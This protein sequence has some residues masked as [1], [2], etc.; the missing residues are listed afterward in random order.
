MISS[1]H[2]Q[3]SPTV[4]FRS[5]TELFWGTNVPYSSYHQDGEG[6]MPKRELVFITARDKQEMQ[7]FI[8]EFFERFLGR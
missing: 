7:S 3:G 5:S 1:G 6:Y 2:L 8:V 4:V